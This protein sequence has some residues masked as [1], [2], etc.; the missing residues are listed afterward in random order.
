MSLSHR[1]KSWRAVSG[2]PSDIFATNF[3]VSEDRAL[4][5]SWGK[6]QKRKWSAPFYVA[7]LIRLDFST[8]SYLDWLPKEWE[9]EVSLT[10]Q[11]SKTDQTMNIELHY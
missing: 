2:D 3:P 4:W 8:T 1:G 5:M 11:T 10:R 7:K 9:T 6:L